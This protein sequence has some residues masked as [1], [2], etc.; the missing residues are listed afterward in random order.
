MGSEKQAQDL[1]SLI[2]R[3][4]NELDLLDERL[5][6]YDEMLLVCIT[7]ENYYFPFLFIL[8]T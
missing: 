8:G 4:L 7:Q 1:L 6:R 5:G 3:G 2:D